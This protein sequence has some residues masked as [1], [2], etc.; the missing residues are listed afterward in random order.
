MVASPRNTDPKLPEG[1]GSY[2]KKIKTLTKQPIKNIL[3]F[4]QQ[5]VNDLIKNLLEKLMLEERKILFRPARRLCK[6]FFYQRFTYK[7]WEGSRFKSASGQKCGFSSC[8]TFA[9]ITLY[10][11]GRSTRKISQF[12]ES[13]Y[14]AY[15]SPQSIS[16]LIKVTEDEV[17][18]LV[19]I[20]SSK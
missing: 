17:R 5:E 2:H 9:V 20:Y 11:V 8:Y 3:T 1:R 10:A 19:F 6:R 4:F 7:V 12:L 15:Y 16:R 13:I 18:S 14:G